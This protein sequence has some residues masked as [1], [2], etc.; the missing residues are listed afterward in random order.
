MKKFALFLFLLLLSAGCFQI[1]ETV[2]QTKY[3][4]NWESID[5]RPIPKWF[6]DAKFGI[7]IHWGLYSV[8]AWCPLP[9]STTNMGDCYAEW[10]WHRLLCQ[11]NERS[12]ALNKWQKEQYG[13]DFKYEDFAPMFKCEVWDPASWAK[14]FKN[15]GAQYV[16]LTS[17]H[18]E[19]F[20]LWPSQYSWNWNSVDIGPH[21]DI[22]G[23]LTN[24]VKNEGMK[25]GFYYSL[26]EWFNPLYLN[27]LDKYVDEHMIPQMKE[28]VNRYHPEIVWTDGEWDHPSE[29]WKS[30]QFL[31]WLYNESPVKETVVVNDRWGKETRNVHGGFYTTEYDEVHGG[32]KRDE[33]NYHPWEESRGIGN[34]YGF[35]RNEKIYNYNTS[36]ELVDILIDKV[37]HGGNFL[38]NVGPTS[39]GRIPVIM[40]ERLADIGKWLKVNG[41]AIYGT[42]M[43][44][45]AQQQKDISAFFT[46]KG[47]DLYVICTKYPTSAITINGLDNK[48]SSVNM[49]GTDAKI[50]YSAG[51]KSVKITP[52]SFTPDNAPCDYAWV[53][54]IADCIKQ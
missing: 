3:Q 30:T 35:N 45:V 12:K 20:A 6:T 8:P 32:I 5:S 10:Y 24:A 34:S 18:H 33:S 19:G 25:M 7:F 26:Y 37:S 23:E 42:S 16:V 51:S 21:R 1:T 31:A 40:Q 47:N 11:D 41:D 9:D 50:K 15:A 46:V 2:A 17:K 14:M 49:L 36:K 52:P 38:L 44:K 13:E 54:K 29:K 4:A 27:N 39:D 53:F 28:L 48:P 43:W 22:A